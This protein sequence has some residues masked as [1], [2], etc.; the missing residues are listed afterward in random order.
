M[1]P[2]F[3]ADCFDT[4]AHLR[5]LVVAGSAVWLGDAACLYRITPA[6]AS[7]YADFGSSGVD[8]SR[9]RATDLAARTA[10]DLD[11]RRG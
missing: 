5:S 3:A 4:L 11:S 6:D 7:N 8:F 10:R 2:G 1:S 9:Q